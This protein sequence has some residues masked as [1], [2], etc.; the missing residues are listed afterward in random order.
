MKLKLEELTFRY[1][2][3]YILNKANYEF[4]NNKIYA[5]LGKNG[6]G[7]TT[8]FNLIKKRFTYE[9]K[10]TLNDEPI[11]YQDI[12]LM[13]SVPNVPDFLT[14]KEY[15]TYFLKLTNRENEDIDYFLNIVNFN[16]KDLDKLICEYSHG[17][18]NKIEFIII[19]ILNPKIILLDEPLTNLDILAQEE[20]K[21]I[22]L[23]LKKDHIIILST[24]II[25]LALNLCD[26]IVIFNNKKLKP[27]TKTKSKIISALKGKN[28]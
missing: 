15:I 23:K 9:G 1:N 21:N 17:M 28:E 16:E 5:L 18:K 14:G 27:I 25:D 2:E 24:H 12:Y 4:E 3:D 20:I 22:L 7:K 8:L 13:N 19:L 11:P 6:V 10:I 26:E